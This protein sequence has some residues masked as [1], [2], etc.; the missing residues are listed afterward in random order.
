M[1][2]PTR[3]P[4][5]GLVAWIL[6][7]VALVVARLP[8]VVEPAG[9][10]QSL[11][12]YVA[13]RVLEGGAP[14]VD[15]WDQKPPGVFFVYA[16]IRSI[17]PA[18]SAVAFA[19]TIASAATALALF[20]VGWRVLGRH[21]AFVSAGTFLLLGHPSIHRLSGLYVRGQSEVFIALAITASL[22]LAW[23]RQPGR[24]HLVAAGL[25]FGVA[26]WL[27]YNAAAYL[28]PLAV[29]L[30]LPPDGARRSW[31]PVA[32]SLL[33]IGTGATLV[34]AGFLAY[35]AAH[36]A[37]G[38]WWRAT[39][40]YNLAYSRETYTAGPWGAARYLVTLPVG[41]MGADMLWYLGGVGV[42]V[43][44]LGAFRRQ[45]PAATLAVSWMTAAVLSIAANGARDLPQYFVQ[46]GPAL[47]FSFAVG[48]GSL[49][50]GRRPLAWLTAVLILLGLWRVGTDAPS[51]AGM[52]WAGLPEA[53]RNI[54]ADVAFA[55]GRVDR[56]DFLARYKGAQ[57]YDALES[58]DLAAH[59][60]ATTSPADRIYVFGFA[61]AVYLESHRLSASRFF[62]SRPVVLEFAAERP[63]Y[64]SQG[65]L[66]D[67]ERNRPAIVALQ[68]RDWA[69]GEPNSE[70][71]FTTHARLGAWLRNGY[72]LDRDTAFFSVWRR[73]GSE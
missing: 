14:Y 30:A 21:M 43:S 17:W 71:F 25:A 65:L 12:M 45:R 72:A 73:R 62:W 3:E 58:D 2:H 34:S 37:I 46:A 69:P 32:T 15:A 16:A 13:D 10:D 47:A 42:V 41:R 67:L 20:V 7:L 57:K 8:A 19:D 6:L 70:A 27:K 39:I 56:R 1:S 5:A 61:P 23:R 35:L 29:A 36:G 44:A 60:R 31:R 51:L 9:S 38:A 33:W 52:R 63:Q 55:R 28:L 49:R 54:A 24:H 64:G 40:D 4:L 48:L 26:V 53:V 18:A 66:T 22:A 59:I 11:Y 68:K 50:G